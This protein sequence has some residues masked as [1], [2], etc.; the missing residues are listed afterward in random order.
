[1]FPLL[2]FEQA[3]PILSGISAMQRIQAANL[4]NNQQGIINKFLPQ[5]SQAEIG[6]MNANTGLMGAQTNKTNIDAKFEPLKNLIE[7]MKAQRQMSRFGE[8]Y[9]LR[10]ALNNMDTPARNTWIA[11][12]VDKYNDMLNTLAD[13]AAQKEASV[14]SDLLT[15]MLSK[16][17]PRDNLTLNNNDQAKLLSAG[18]ANENQTQ[19]HPVFSFGNDQDFIDEV[20]QDPSL[21]KALMS[22]DPIGN[23]TINANPNPQNTVAQ[24][25]LPVSPVMQNLFGTPTQDQNDQLKRALELS[26]NKK[27]TT[28]KTWNQLEG[29]IQVLSM[30]ENPE[31]IAKAKRASEYAGMLN[32]PKEAIDRWLQQNPGAIDDYISFKSH[33][34]PEILNRFKGLEA[35]GTTDAQRQEL[36][37]MYQAMDSASSN[38]QRFMTQLK[39]FTDSVRRVHSSVAK[40]ASPMF[41]VDKGSQSSK[42]NNN[43]YSEQDLQHTAQKY[44][45]SVDQVKRKLGIS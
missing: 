37:R 28:T 24:Q 15:Q 2:T 44:G 18:I 21:L 39:L 3:N 20:K 32:K 33:D 19:P 36:H 42:Y 43:K 34:I 16:Y 38:P 41:D 8:A 6:N 25:T 31:F 4:L 13:K 30:L 23:S 5:K 40:S 9:E 45:I 26:V 1:M 11:Q 27:L 29:G 17:F 22:Q 12:H 10:A 7:A 14:G 35:M